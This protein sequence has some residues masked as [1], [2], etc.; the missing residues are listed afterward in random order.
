MRPLGVAKDQGS[1]CYVA[2]THSRE[3]LRGAQR[4]RSSYSLYPHFS[5]STSALF[6]SQSGTGP[7]RS[8]DVSNTLGYNPGGARRSGHHPAAT[9]ALRVLQVPLAWAIARKRALITEQSRADTVTIPCSRGGSPD[10]ELHASRKRGARGLR[11]QLAA[12]PLGVGKGASGIEW[13][14]PYTRRDAVLV[15]VHC[16]SAR[17]GACRPRSAE[18]FVAAA[19]FTHMALLHIDVWLVASPSMSVSEVCVSNNCDLTEGPGALGNAW[20]HG[21]EFLPWR[22]CARRR[23]V[24][25]CCAS[26]ASLAAVLPRRWCPPG[27]T[28]SRVLSRETNTDISPAIVPKI[29]EQDLCLLLH[30][31]TSP[32]SLTHRPRLGASIQ[33]AAAPD[34]PRVSPSHVVYTYPLVHRNRTTHTSGTSRIAFT[35]VISPTTGGGREVPAWLRKIADVF[36]LS[37][38]SQLVR[39]NRVA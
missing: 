21:G 22:W 19:R 5:I 1:R 30:A 11:A 9:R 32:R 39:A 25:A 3:A 14:R 24:V 31:D 29:T 18:R 37:P 13:L 10:R 8:A 35:Q 36:D 27:C 28:A 34:R 38:T 33:V 12:G 6:A 20:R 16:R 15:S 7:E 23:A 17:A 2:I 4:A 26:R